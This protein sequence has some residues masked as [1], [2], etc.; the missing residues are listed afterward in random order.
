VLAKKSKLLLNTSHKGSWIKWWWRKQGHDFLPMDMRKKS[1]ICYGSIA[2]D[3]ILV[4]S[5]D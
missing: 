2:I 3:G 4:W 1:A 5:H